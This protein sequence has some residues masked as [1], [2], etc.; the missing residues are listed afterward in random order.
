MRR[1]IYNIYKFEFAIFTPESLCSTNVIAI[2]FPYWKSNERS[3]VF[4]ACHL[5][6]VLEILSAHLQGT[7]DWLYPSLSLLL[8]EV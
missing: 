2:N 5:A 4:V 3:R 6:I 1:Y 7:A 8:K